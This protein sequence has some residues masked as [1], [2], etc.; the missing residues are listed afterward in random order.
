VL[1]LALWP[2][3]RPE[4]RVA[5]ELWRE[6]VPWC[7][8]NRNPLPVEG[9][10]RERF[11]WLMSEVFTQWEVEH[12]IRS[13]RIFTK[14]EGSSNG[15]P[16]SLLD[17]ENNAQWKVV[18]DIA[19]GVTIDDVYFP[20]PPALVEAIRASEPYYGPFPQRDETGQRIYGPD[21]RFE[22][23]DLMRAAIL[24]HP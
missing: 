16:M 1:L 24:K 2:I 21:P 20:P 4:L 19:T 6:F 12:V 9:E 14:G 17:I 18:S 11:V 5:E 10:L 13:G 15:M 22:D 3:L 8:S 23:C 7:G